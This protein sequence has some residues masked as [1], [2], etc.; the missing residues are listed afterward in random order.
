MQSLCF[1]QK[2]KAIEGATMVWL[3]D[4][5]KIIGVETDEN[6]D[7]RKIKIVTGDTVTI[8]PNVI[9]KIYQPNDIALFNRAKFHYK[10]GGLIH[11]NIGASDGFGSF[12]ISYSKRFRGKF[13]LGAGVGFHSNSFF[14]S[15]TSSFHW[16]TV[17]SAPIFVQGRYL[18]NTGK[19]MFYAKGRLGY[20]NNFDSWGIT[21]VKDGFMLDASIGCMFATKRRYKYFVELGQYTSYASGMA[22]NRDPMGL[23]DI[24][25][26]MWFNN[27]NLT[28]GIE[29]GR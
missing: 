17:Q 29:I 7:Y 16:V 1:G 26:K 12:D 13:E 28:F 23:S 24:G 21:Q 27:V 8:K 4:G 19:Y 3:K 6:E 20:A 15:T 14:F 2:N 11:A 5:S 10:Q 9:R 18:I 22:I 25:F